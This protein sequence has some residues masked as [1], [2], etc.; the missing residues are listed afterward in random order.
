MRLKPA[1]R[2]AFTENISTICTDRL[3][4]EALESLKV[5][6][7][8]TM[9]VWITRQVYRERRFWDSSWVEEN[10][11]TLWQVLTG[12]KKEPQKFHLSHPKEWELPYGRCFGRKDRKLVVRL[13]VKWKVDGED[14][15]RYSYQHVEEGPMYGEEKFHFFITDVEI[16]PLTPQQAAFVGAKCLTSVIPS[17]FWGTRE[18]V[19]EIQST[20]AI[21]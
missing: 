1:H 6:P 14:K 10:K 20:F 3:Y 16:F 18:D 5:A 2:G 4:R 9:S 19:A 13:Q 17:I 7:L 12:V 8:P 15:D 11:R 21:A